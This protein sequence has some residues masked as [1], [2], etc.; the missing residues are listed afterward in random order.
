MV[1]ATNSRVSRVQPIFKWLAENGEPTWPK[2]L[3]S[4]AGDG[5]DPGDVQKVHLDPEVRVPASAERREWMLRYAA[6]LTA[7]GAN[8]DLLK[9]RIEDG[10]T[11]LEGQTSADCLI[12]CE[13]MT[14]WIEGKR[15]DKLSPGIRFD[16]KRDQLAR[17]L[18]A[19]WIRAGNEKDFRVIVCSEQPLTG[20]EKDL[21]EAYRSG[22][23]TKAVE[24]L[25][26]ATR[27][28]FQVRLLC[29]QWSQIA[30]RWDGMRNLTELFD[31]D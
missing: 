3:L 5:G 13:Y 26:D 16:D 20:Y 30:D 17:N 23:L 29:L 7:K 28:M 4:L 2:A 22:T 24:H 27:E 25:E 11:T 21:V 6:S 8:S 9:K 12:E 1:S 31:L 14:I 18:E 10:A 19:A 15:T